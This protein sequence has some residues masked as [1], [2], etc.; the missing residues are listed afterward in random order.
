MR[1][2]GAALAT[3]NFKDAILLRHCNLFYY[4]LVFSVLLVLC[5]KRRFKG[6]DT[7]LIFALE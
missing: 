4:L 3:R 7:K 6:G 1:E 5:K 2:V